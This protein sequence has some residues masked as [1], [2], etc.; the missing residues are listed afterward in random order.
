MTGD[1]DDAT[2]AV[3]GW[4]TRIEQAMPENG[5]LTEQVLAE[6]GQLPVVIKPADPAEGLSERE[7]MMRRA[8]ARGFAEGF[9]K[10]YAKAQARSRSQRAWIQYG[11]LRDQDG[12]NTD[13]SRALA[14]GTY[15]GQVADWVDSL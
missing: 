6:A 13:A 7:A 5:D 2:R 15:W 3:D 8:A 1:N 10:S 14:Q 9:A 11:S 4:I 12:D